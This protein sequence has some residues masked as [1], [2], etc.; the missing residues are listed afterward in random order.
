MNRLFALVWILAGCAT[1]FAQ[2]ITTLE[3]IGPGNGE[4]RARLGQ[5]ATPATALR[6]VANAAR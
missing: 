5:A 1:A 3:K 2:D 4:D 6:C